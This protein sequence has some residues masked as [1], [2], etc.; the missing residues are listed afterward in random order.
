LVTNKTCGCGFRRFAVQSVGSRSGRGGRLYGGRGA[1]PHA[2]VQGTADAGGRCAGT[3]RGAELG[4]K[5][6]VEQ[7]Q[8]RGRGR[9]R[10]RRRSGRVRRRTRV[11]VIRGEAHQDGTVFA[12]GQRLFQRRRKGRGKGDEQRQPVAAS[13]V[14]R[15]RRRVRIRREAQLV[16]DGRGRGRDGHQHVGFGWYV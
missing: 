14:G 7:Q 15:R 9:R 2:R 10:R 1:Q 8:Q 3:E 16:T 5:E 11:D 6:D 4:E 13:T 12:A